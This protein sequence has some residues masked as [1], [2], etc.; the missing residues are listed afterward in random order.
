MNCI[1]Q[2]DGFFTYNN[3]ITPKKVHVDQRNYINI[4]SLTSTQFKGVFVTK[5]VADIWA[6]VFSCIKTSVFWSKKI[7]K[8][9][10]YFSPFNKNLHF[11]SGQRFCPPPPLMDMSAKNVSFFTAPL[12]LVWIKQSR[13]TCFMISALFSIR[14][15][16]YSPFHK[17]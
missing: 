2:Y 4:I 8:I 11:H 13:S 6:K 5:A 9:L 16:W 17:T 3:T 14:L 15:L 10:S 1:P 12:I 7:M